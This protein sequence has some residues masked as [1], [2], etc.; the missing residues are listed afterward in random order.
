MLFFLRPRVLLFILDS[1]SRLLKNHLVRLDSPDKSGL[2]ISIQMNDFWLDKF[3]PNGIPSGKEW[4]R[5]MS[6]LLDRRSIS[7]LLEA[8]SNIAQSP[9]QLKIVSH[10]KSHDR[11]D[12]PKVFER[13][14]V[15]F[16]IAIHIS[17]SVHGLCKSRLNEGSP[18]R[19]FLSDV[20]R[21]SIR[22]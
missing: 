9:E 4:L 13:A 17:S 11:N 14:S 10:D 20:L 15:D 5:Q 6:D 18:P 22:Q 12:F 2:S 8:T 7:N 1:I 16:F 3:R 21:R 19:S